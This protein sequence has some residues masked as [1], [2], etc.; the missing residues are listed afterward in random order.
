M[1]RQAAAAAL[2]LLTLT[3]ISKRFGGV[4]ALRDVDLSVDRGEVRGLVGENGSGKTTLVRVLAGTVRP[5]AGSV[6]VGE[7]ELAA[8]DPTAR[9][10]AGVGVVFQEASVCPDL[11]VGENLFMGR[12]SSRGFVSWR[13]V[14]R[15]STEILAGR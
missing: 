5:D 6:H 7:A 10:R 15:R 12:L 1:D 8:L 9:L 11:S 14:H 13:E 3:G 4:Q 2:K